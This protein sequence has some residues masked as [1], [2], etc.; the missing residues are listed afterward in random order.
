MKKKVNDIQV[1]PIIT[2]VIVIG[3]VYRQEHLIG[4]FLF[5]FGQVDEENRNL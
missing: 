1:G 3:N 5:S 4:I 2:L